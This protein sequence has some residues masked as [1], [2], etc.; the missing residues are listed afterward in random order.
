MRAWRGG[1]GGEGLVNEMDW[2]LWW[3]IGGCRKGEHKSK[4]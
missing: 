3:V 4:K 2:C 1:G